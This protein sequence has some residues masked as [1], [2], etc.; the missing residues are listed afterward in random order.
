MTFQARYSGP[1]A[2]DCGHWI[3]PGDLIR[4]AGDS[5]TDGYVHAVC[6]ADDL[7]VARTPCPRCFQVPAANGLC[8]CDS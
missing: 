7:T 2:A 6:P 3:Q 8:G 4:G 5:H 1:C